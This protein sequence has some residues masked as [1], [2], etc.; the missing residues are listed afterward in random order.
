[1]IHNVQWRCHICG[2]TRSDEKISIYKR[3]IKEDDF[4]LEINIRYCNDNPD[5]ESK[6]EWNANSLYMHHK[7][8]IPKG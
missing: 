7:K 3:E 5:C 6:V 4:E 8:L 1:M 2:K